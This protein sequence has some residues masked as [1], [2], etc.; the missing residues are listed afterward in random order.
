MDIKKPIFERPAC[1]IMLM[2]IPQ[3]LSLKGKLLHKRHSLC[4]Y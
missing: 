3:R 1:I 4:R 2:L